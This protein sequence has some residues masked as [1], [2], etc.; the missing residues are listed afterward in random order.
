[1]RRFSFILIILLLPK[2]TISSEIKSDEELFL[3]PSYAY[4]AGKERAMINL[5]VWV[6]EPGENRVKR[7]LLEEGLEK[8]IK[9]EIT[10]KQ[11]TIYTRRIK[12]FLVD[13][14]RNK[15]ITISILGRFFNLGKTKPDGHLYSELVIEDSEILRQLVDKKQVPYKIKLRKNET[16]NFSGFITFIPHKGVS[17]ISDIDDT[18]KISNVLD[19]KDLIKNTFL[20]DF[21]PVSGM[22]PLYNRWEKG[23]AVFH[24]V[25]GSPWQLYQPVSG[26][27]ETSGF[28]RGLFF[29]KS[30]RL[31][32]SAIY[33]F[34]KADQLNYKTGIIKGIIRK[35]PGRKYILVGDS[36]EKDPEVYSEIARRYPEKILFILIRNVTDQKP[37]APRYR[38]LFPRGFPVRWKIFKDASELEERYLT[39]F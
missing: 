36:G 10:S 11:K 3:F 12:P 30:F 5:H 22:S 16:R 8:I 24:Y 7:K 18:I 9:S 35:F 39:G 34:I 25:S 33:H 27:L 37:G 31:K 13:N 17:V 20:K 38:K 1:M 29:L 14:E 23:G 19:K 21:Q 32:P 2:Q 6:Y 15:E 28:P 26:F 4:L